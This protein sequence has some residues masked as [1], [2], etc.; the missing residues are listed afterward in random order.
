MNDK[1]ALKYIALFL[2]GLKCDKRKFII[3]YYNHYCIQKVKPTNRYYLQPNDNWC[4]AFVS[5]CAHMSRFEA[6]NFPYGV[7]VHSQMIM[8]KNLLELTTNS[9]KVT[10]GDLVL[11]DWEG[12]GLPNH[13][14]I[15]ESIINGVIVSVEGNYSNDIKTRTIN[16]SNNKIKGYII[17]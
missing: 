8:A 6:S 7:S 3:D 12:D 16:K 4:G 10:S 5:V 9:E 15:V 13:I 1:T 17:I 11:F 2:T 14:G